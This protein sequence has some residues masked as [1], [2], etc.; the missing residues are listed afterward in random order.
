MKKIFSLIALLTLGNALFAQQFNQYYDYKPVHFG[1]NVGL[2][3][4][5]FKLTEKRSFRTNDSLKT[6]LPVA[7]PGFQLAIVSDFRLGE[8]ASLRIVPTLLFA[9][10][11]VKYEFIEGKQQYN[12]TQQV[13]S[14]YIEVPVMLKLRSDR[15]NNYRVYMITGLKYMYDW[16]SQQRVNNQ[17]NNNIKINRNDFAWEIGIGYDY[18]FPY[19]KFAP[20]LKLATGLNNILV[21]ENHLYASPLQSLRSRTLILSFNFE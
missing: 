10:K 9:Q 11:D 18:Y 12:K 6:I 21:A 16:S 17:S 8:H 1:F 14:T 19:F 13:R 3:S 4:S 5:K 15:I 20:E 7:F 2:N